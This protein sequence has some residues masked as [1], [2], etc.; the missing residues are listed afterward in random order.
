MANCLAIDAGSA[1]PTSAMMSPPTASVPMLDHGRSSDSDGSPTGIG[2]SSPTVSTVS[3]PTTPENTSPMT[4][5]TATPGNNRWT[6]RPPSMTVSVMAASSRSAGIQ[7]PGWPTDHKAWPRVEPSGAVAAVP[8][9]LGTWEEMM[10]IAAAEVKP[11]R[12]GS[13]IRYASHPNRPRPRSSRQTPTMKARSAA[14][15]TYSGSPLVNPAPWSAARVSRLVRATGPVCRYGDDANNEKAI[16]GS[17]DANSPVTTGISA[18]WAYARDWGISTRATLTP[19]TRSAIDGFGASN[20]GFT[21][22]PYGWEPLILSGWC[23]TWSAIAAMTRGA[24][25]I[26]PSGGTSP[27]KSNTSSAAPNGSSSNARATV[28]EP[29]LAS[30]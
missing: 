22:G 10:M 8:M 28:S 30:R 19:A 14:S 25:R 15:L 13:T 9:A 2:V 1:N 6:R 24:P 17:A 11:F 20:H 12:T 18:I 23:T 16:S 3:S 29:S 4:T 27:K 26:A 21:V 7:A 5:A